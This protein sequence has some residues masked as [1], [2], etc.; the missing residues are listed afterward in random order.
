MLTLK[1]GLCEPP[2]KGRSIGDNRHQ[3]KGTERAERLMDVIDSSLE[4]E[5]ITIQEVSDEQYS[6]G[7]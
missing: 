3:P 7:E 5:S 1:Y 6:T 2:K 4:E